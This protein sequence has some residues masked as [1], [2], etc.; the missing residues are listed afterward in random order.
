MLSGRVLNSRLEA[1]CALAV[2]PRVPAWWRGAGT[3]LGWGQI[4]IPCQPPAR[5]QEHHR[6]YQRRKIDFSVWHKQG[7]FTNWEDLLVDR[8]GADWRIQ[9]A[10]SDKAEWRSMEIG[11]R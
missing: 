11:I 1:D 3:G 7:K 6:P 2:A 5:K 10:N 4:G 8:L 9:R